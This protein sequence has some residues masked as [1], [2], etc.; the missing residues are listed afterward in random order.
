[1][2]RDFLRWVMAWFSSSGE[3]VPDAPGI[4]YTMP[5]RRIHHTAPAHRI[6]YTVRET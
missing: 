1:M 3:I 5:D 2:M 4:E 6:H